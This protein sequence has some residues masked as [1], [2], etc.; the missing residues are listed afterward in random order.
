MIQKHCNK[1]SYTGCPLTL[2]QILFS[3]ALPS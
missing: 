1:I 2:L 3:K